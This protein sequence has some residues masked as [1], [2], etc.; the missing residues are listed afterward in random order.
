MFR[1]QTGVGPRVRPGGEL[2]TGV[3]PR[4]PPPLM[5][6]RTGALGVEAGTEWD[7]DGLP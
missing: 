5:T 4:P 6:I 3:P 1:G 2:N 7:G